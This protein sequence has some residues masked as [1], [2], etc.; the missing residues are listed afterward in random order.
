MDFGDFFDV[1]YE[2][3]EAFFDESIYLEEVRRYQ[4][5]YSILDVELRPIVGLNRRLFAIVA[6][7]ALLNGK[8]PATVTSST[9]DAIEHLVPLLLFLVLLHG[10]D[11][12]EK[13]LE[14]DCVTMN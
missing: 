7:I 2:E 6:V 13:P 9:T 11:V 3:V 4:Y 5:G 8:L 1:F 10:E 14:N 12:V